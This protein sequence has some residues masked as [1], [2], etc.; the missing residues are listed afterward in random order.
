ME[1]VDT[2]SI[3]RAVHPVLRRWRAEGA[4][5]RAIAHVV[6]AAAEG[7][8]FPTNLDLDQ[9]VGSMVPQ[10]EAELLH[11]ALDED[12]ETARLVDELEAQQA[13]RRSGVGG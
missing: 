9:P 3:C 5:A 12:W 4:D 2:A 13:R 1:T 6:A 8:P 11:R 7:Y 10:T